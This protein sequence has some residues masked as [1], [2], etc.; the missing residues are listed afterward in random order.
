MANHGRRDA[1]AT[2]GFRACHAAGGGGGGHV[3]VAMMSSA[4][5]C[6]NADDPDHAR[7]IVRIIMLAICDRDSGDRIWRYPRP[8][9]P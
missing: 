2:D 9:P 7:A 1:K 5:H 6:S 8:C 4:S 3:V